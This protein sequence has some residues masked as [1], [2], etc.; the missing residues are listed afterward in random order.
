MTSDHAASLIR[1]AFADT[2]GSLD[3]KMGAGDASLDLKHFEKCDIVLVIPP[4]YDVYQGHLACH[5]LQ[6]V[7]RKS[8]FDVRVLYGNLLFARMLGHH[9]YRTLLDERVSLEVVFQQLAFGDRSPEGAQR[10]L[11]REPMLGQAVDRSREWLEVI[12]QILS[13]MQ[14]KVVG[15]A[16]SF[17]Q[18]TSS[19]ALLERCIDDI[20]GVT[21]VIGGANCEAEMAHGLVSTGT[22]IH[23][24]ASGESEET[25]IQ[26]LQDV[27]VN[28]T[29]PERVLKGQPCHRMDALPLPDYDEFFAQHDLFFGTDKTGLAGPVVPHESSR[30]CW[31]GEKHHCTF[32]GLNGGGMAFREKPPEKI[33][34]ELTTLFDRYKVE[35]INMTD[36][37]M[38]HRY[39]RTVL[40]TLAERLPPGV[41][42]F[43]E[44]K[45][46][47]SLERAELLRSARIDDIQ[48]G[49]EALDT[50]LLKCMNKG[51]TGA[52]NLRLLRYG[53]ALGIDI[54]W[55]LLQEFPGDDPESYVQTLA[56]MQLISHLQ[57]PSS[58]SPLRIDRFSP[59]HSF[60]ER[61]GI[62]SLRPMEFY[63]AIFPI[64][65]DCDKLAYYFDADYESG[66][67]DCPEVIEKID[68]V[69]DSWNKH[70]KSFDRAMLCF[71]HLAADQYLLIDS[72]DPDRDQLTEIVS[73]TRMHAALTSA[74]EHDPETL[75]WL[76][77]RRLVFEMD[78]AYQPLA[79]AP[80]EI[81]RE[82]EQTDCHTQFTPDPRLTVAV[83][84]G[85]S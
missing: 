38:P 61:Y 83:E 73:A 9:F 48:P 19:I 74:A 43:Y 72:R 4:F 79:T 56:L 14:P 23:H 46:N 80:V 42:L 1:Y 55:N 85:L 49:I 37:I 77:A 52:Q 35:R 24:I 65:T 31:W 76:K 67:Q 68:V 18:L 39:F 17:E 70:W 32:C 33:I 11:D 57:P 50:G 58:S 7:A 6:A 15:S 66:A 75:D 63:S 44:Q 20:P 21:T 62:Q 28:G 12:M 47:I 45:A 25:F 53:R 59:F 69:A 41:T 16:C 81:L 71:L 40:P 84:Y 10:Y 27:L 51:T 82:V 60:P 13:W 54:S 26:L 36:N 2:S 78:G 3:A 29:T 8:G 64:G 30:G 22:R 34:A 5:L